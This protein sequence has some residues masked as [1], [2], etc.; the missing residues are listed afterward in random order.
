MRCPKHPKYRGI[1]RPRCD[2]RP[3]WD[4]WHRRHGPDMK[5]AL[6]DASTARPNRVKEDPVCTS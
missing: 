6:D 5:E 3:C 4:I 1:H 2:C